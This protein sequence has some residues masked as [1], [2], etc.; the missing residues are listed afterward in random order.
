MNK[1]ILV[2][3]GLGFIGSHLCLYLL[4][5]GQHV[6]CI[7]NLSTGQVGNLQE[8]EAYPEFE[9]I[10]G[11]IV[12]PIGLDGTIDEIYNLACPASPVHCQK[13][14][15]KTTQTCVMGVLNMLEL[16]RKYNCKILHASTSEVYGDPG[17]HSQPES[18]WG[19][20]NPCGIRSCYDEG[21]RCA[22]SLCMDYHR[23]YGVKVK[24][25][26]IFNTYGPRM[27]E[28]DGRV[29]SNFIL[30]ALKGEPL[31]IYGDG[32]QTRS[33]QYIDDLVEAMMRMMGTADV[34]TGPVNIGNP[35]EYTILELAKMV[36]EQTGSLSR[37]ISKSLP[38]DDPRRRRPDIS[39]AYRMLN[40]W[41][42]KI[43]LQEGLVKTIDYFRS[44]IKQ[45]EIKTSEM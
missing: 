14:P 24:V 41:Q 1:R 15:I 23:Q 2:T 27:A 38:Q 7:D 4:K 10:N 19:H 39:L 36:I 33:F 43:G 37:I 35:E 12:N 40:G 26:R 34:F 11:D 31:T 3:G 45:G 17:V 22:E 28:D 5:K 6:I 20:V 29:V 18:Y 13:N 25:I 21:K 42:P 9:Y 8:M 32:G 44:V 30:Q 16:A